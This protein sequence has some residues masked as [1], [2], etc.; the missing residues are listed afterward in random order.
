MKIITEDPD[1]KYWDADESITLIENG[2][3]L[4]DKS[5]AIEIEVKF[6]TISVEIEPSEIEI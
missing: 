5:C 2:I 3:D 4:C 6:E 1:L